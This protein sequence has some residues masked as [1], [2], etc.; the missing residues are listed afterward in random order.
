MYLNQLQHREYFITSSSASS[1][2]SSSSSSTTISFITAFLS[3]LT[4]LTSSLKSSLTLSLTHSLLSRYNRFD[5][6]CNYFDN[7]DRFDKIYKE[8]S[9]IDTYRPN[10][11]DTV[12][13]PVVVFLTKLLSLLGDSKKSDL[14]RILLNFYLTFL[15]VN[16]FIR[17]YI[18]SRVI[19]RTLSQ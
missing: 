4:P 16:L 11:R 1:S 14:I 10:I 5:K 9:Y 6:I 17:F 12:K 15:V 13:D 7:Y 8:S 18:T 2:S 19:T 3:S